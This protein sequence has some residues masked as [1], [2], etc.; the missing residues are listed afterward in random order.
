MQNSN[1]NMT[2]DAE[3]VINAQR[4]SKHEKL[5]LGTTLLLLTYAE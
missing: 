1:M 5:M 4:D 2:T 3:H